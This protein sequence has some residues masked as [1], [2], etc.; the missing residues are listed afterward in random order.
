M[1]LQRFTLVLLG[2]ALVSSCTA[3]IHPRPA[4]PIPSNL[5][6]QDAEIILLFTIANQPLP[7]EWSPGER[8]ADQA[9]QALF[10]RWRYQSA[11]PVGQ[12][13]PESV[14]PS[15][16]VVGRQVGVLYMRVE[17]RVNAA[18]VTTRILDSRNFNQSEGHIH[19]TAL[20]WLDELETN[21]RRTLGSEAALR[22]LGQ[23]RR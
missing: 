21:I 19:P 12:W 17:M 3:A 14:A 10:G 22:K 2:C 1:R 8:I 11:Q 7:P 15:I 20:V 5:S 16:L 9:M 18:G 6:P 4:I 23:D 13:F